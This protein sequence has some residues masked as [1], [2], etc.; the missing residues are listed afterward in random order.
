MRTTHITRG[1]EW[2]P[3]VPVHLELFDSMG[4]TRPTYAHLPVIMKL[5][6]GNRRKLSKRKDAEAAVS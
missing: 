5:D 3:S 2:M 4:W 6:N 1:E